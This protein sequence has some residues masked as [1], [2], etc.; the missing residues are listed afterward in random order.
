MLTPQAWGRQYK[1]LRA[2]DVLV[3]LGRSL[4]A[5]LHDTDA[6]HIE[7]KGFIPTKGIHAAG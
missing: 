2:S 1:A 6:I 7:W 4:P 5:H 3:G